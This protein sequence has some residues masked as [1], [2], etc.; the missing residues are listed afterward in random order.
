MTVLFLCTFIV[1]D[2]KALFKFKISESTKIRHFQ[3]KIQTLFGERQYL[4]R[5]DCRAFGASSPSAKQ[6]SLPLA[7]KDFER[8][9]QIIF[10]YLL[11]YFNIC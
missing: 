11:E 7:A 9:N 5:H 2:Y 10:D 3:I 4:R 1:F 8:L 6:K